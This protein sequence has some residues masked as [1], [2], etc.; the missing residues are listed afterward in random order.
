MSRKP[1]ILKAAAELFAAKGYHATS[2][3]E[4]ADRAELSEGIIFYY[5][6]T[7]EHIMMG[8]L[9]DI[10][11]AYLIGTYEVME[12]V[13]NGWEAIKAFIKIHFELREERST[14]ILCLVRDFPAGLTDLS[15]PHRE[16][17]RRYHHRLNSLVKGALERGGKDGSLRPC[18]VEETAF[19]LI[20]LLTSI[21]RYDLLNLT[22]E[23][24]LL[25]ETLDFVHRALA[26]TP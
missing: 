14:E 22:P 12:N 18:P 1:D 24:D 26:P 8:I 9:E 6:K 5:F 13:A 20:G 19:L 7:K 2:T 15:S 10:F 25:A 11:E 23:A 21:P 17:I 16:G 3:H 4:I